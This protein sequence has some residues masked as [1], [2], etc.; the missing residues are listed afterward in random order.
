TSI[1]DSE[2]VET[3]ETR[4]DGSRVE[5]AEVTATM[6]VAHK[7]HEQMKY[8]VE[9]AFAGQPA[10]M[11]RIGLDDY[12]VARSSPQK[13]ALYLKKLYSQANSAAYKP[14]LLAA[15]CTQAKIDE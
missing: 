11:D 14:G 12:K 2:T 7:K 3:A 6:R 8:F 15:N 9:K 10:V 5:T 13:M 1:E 4:D